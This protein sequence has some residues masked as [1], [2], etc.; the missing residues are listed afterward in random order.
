MIGLMSKVSAVI[1]THKLTDVRDSLGTEGIGGITVT[2][3][4][5]YGRQKGHT[6]NYRG[7][8]YK[9][10]FIPKV[11]VEVVVA[12][13]ILPNII[14]AIQKAAGTGNIGD[15]KIWVTPIEDVL[16]IRTGERGLDAV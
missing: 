16:R 11:M 3:V 15:G 13:A 12:H 8:E 2:E 7:A 1:Q 10:N 6:Q 9:V 5:G 4:M 14:A